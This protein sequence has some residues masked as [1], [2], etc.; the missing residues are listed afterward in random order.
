MSVGKPRLSRLVRARLTRQIHG[1]GCGKLSDKKVT[2][3]CSDRTFDSDRRTITIGVCMMARISL[4][5][6][7]FESF[8]SK[9][10]QFAS[11]LSL[12][13]TFV[14]PWIVQTRLLIKFLYR[15]LSS[16]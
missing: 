13:N 1:F 5:S 16:F 10:G 4:E 7:R 6:G 2:K 11:K 12:M 15:A 14:R 3:A 9:Q 8:I